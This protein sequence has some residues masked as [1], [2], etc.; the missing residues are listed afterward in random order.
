M[1]FV[2]FFVLLC[3]FELFCFS[4]EQN[5]K[6][7]PARYVVLSQ[8]IRNEVAERCAEK[9]HMAII[10]DRAGLMKKVN[11]LG[12]DFRIKGP[13]S[14]EKLREILVDCVEGLLEALNGNEEIRPSLK[15]YPFNAEGVDIG[16]FI[17]DLK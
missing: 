5:N 8:Q 1:R 2:Y 10:S 6:Y 4:G 16:I 15:T 9:Y 17:S 7:V 14:Q 11:L 12:N 3:S 13:L